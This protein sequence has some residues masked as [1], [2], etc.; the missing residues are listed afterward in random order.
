MKKSSQRAASEQ[1]IFNFGKRKAIGKFDGGDISGLGGLPIFQLLEQSSGF[2]RGLTDCIKDTR[3]KKSTVHSLFVVI[4]QAVLLI[5]AGHPKGIEC[6]Y[7]QN[8]PILALL[9]GKDGTTSSQAT[10]SRL[11]NMVTK[12]DILRCLS[13]LIR[14][15]IGR[16]TTPPSLIELNFDGSAM[17]T[18]GR[19]QYIAFN[20]YYDKQMYFPLFVFDQRGWLLGIVL[21]GGA[22]NDGKIALPVLQM[23]VKRL[24]KAWPKTEILFRAD[25]AFGN[26][27][28]FQWCQEQ[29]KPVKYIVGLRGNNNLYTGSQHLDWAVK[30][31]FRRRFGPEHFIGSFKRQKRTKE[32]E[33]QTLPKEE[34]LGILKHMAQRTVRS[35]GEFLHQ[36]GNGTGKTKSD[37]QIRVIAKSEH[38]DT[39]AHHR[40]IATNLD[41]ANPTYLYEQMYGEGRGRTELNIREFKSLELSLSCPEAVANQF[42]LILHTVAY[43]FYMMLRE[44]LPAKYA[45]S[46]MV[47]L[48]KIFCRIAVQVQVTSRQLW[49]RWT[50]SFPPQV[51]FLNLC[52]RLQTA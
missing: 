25:A 7:F 27:N 40:Y 32:R 31:T 33:A 39:G 9:L 5:V 44:Q 43:N 19:Q 23:I 13:F 4:W 17:E 6:D 8:D 3:R 37:P 47:T 20:N 38:N 14:F 51:A 11:E 28:V 15:Y 21:R 49:L 36:I 30:A 35:F 50:S 52:K 26:K 46:S 29:E 18:Y 10:R 48:Q 12:R 34:R 41:H 24:R 2:V 45:K 16:F 22:E 1:V 42:R